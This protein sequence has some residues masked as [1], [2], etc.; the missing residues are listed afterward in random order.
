MKILI[1]GGA[2]FI[3]SHVAEA[4]ADGNEITILDDM[5]AGR[6]TQTR[7]KLKHIPV[8]YATAADVFDFD[9]IIH[10]AAQVS[11]FK[12]VDLPIKDFYTNAMG[13]FNLFEQIRN[14][15]PDCKVIYT[16]SR[17]VLG[18]IPQGISDETY[19]YNPS[20]FYNV[21]KM[22]GE[23]LCK[24]YSELYDMNFIILRPSNVYGERQPYWVGGWYN[25]I[26]HW[27][28]LALDK[29]K[30]PIYGDGKQIR[31]YT[32]VKDIAQAYKLAMEKELWDETFILAS[33][34]GHSLLTIASK[35][36]ALCGNKEDNIEF[37]PR[38]K[39]DIDRFVGNSDKAKK[40]LGWE[41]KTDIDTGLKNEF[42]WI[43]Y[44]L[45][46]KK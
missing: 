6:N 9:W 13:T 21:H 5:S 17:S 8:E 32:Y 38:R 36:N 11:T 12:S 39:G 46:V 41:C 22:Y 18:N 28:Q 31:D 1:T 16:S 20:T 29:K 10:C 24:I 25:F 26:A 14:F 45:G 23:H 37:L 30:I 44:S 34:K 35:V 42:E 27:F 4:I 40:M 15:N 43:Q 33:G 2:G 7:F 3:G 19:P